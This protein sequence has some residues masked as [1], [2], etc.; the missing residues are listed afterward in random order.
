MGSSTMTEVRVHAAFTVEDEES[1]LR[2]ARKMVDATQS[3]KG[4]L[5]YQLYREAGKAA[6]FAMIE[7]WETQGTSL[8]M[9]SRLMLRL[10]WKLRKGMS[11]LLFSYLKQYNNCFLT[12]KKL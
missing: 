3:E 8:F 10:S 9:A 5:H 7:T 4:C 2:E 12:N 1:F 11:K 6:S